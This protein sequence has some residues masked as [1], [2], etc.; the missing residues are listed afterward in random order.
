VHD[1]ELAHELTRLDGLRSTI[2]R[3]VVEPL[4]AAAVE[5]LRGRDGA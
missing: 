5:F 3:W 1:P 2:D 4:R